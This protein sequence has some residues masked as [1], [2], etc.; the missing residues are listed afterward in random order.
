MYVRV[1]SQG[2]EFYLESQKIHQ[3]EISFLQLDQGIAGPAELSTRTPNPNSKTE[4][5]T[6]AQSGGAFD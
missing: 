2:V 4:F 5:T 1:P 3:T 6:E